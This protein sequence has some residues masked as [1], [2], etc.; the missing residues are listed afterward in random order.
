MKR[1]SLELTLKRGL[2][3]KVKITLGVLVM[4]LINGNVSYTD[5]IPKNISNVKVSESG[6]ISDISQL[7][8]NEVGGL[9]ISGSPVNKFE[10]DIQ[11]INVAVNIDPAKTSGVVNVLGMRSTASATEMADNLKINAEIIGDYTGGSSTVIGVQSLIYAGGEGEYLRLG[12][13]TKV[14]IK[15]DGDHK[16]LIATGLHVQGSDYTTITTIG[17]GSEININTSSGRISGIYTALAT[18]SNKKSKI[19]IEDDV[20][21]KVE[22]AKEETNTSAYDWVMA[23]N[24]Y[25][26]AE[27]I[28]GDRLTLEIKTEADALKGS[29]VANYTLNNKEEGNITIGN[30]AKITSELILKEK[31]G[32]VYTIVNQ[33]KSNLKIG[34]NAVISAKGENANEV[35]AISNMGDSNLTIGEG[36]NISVTGENSTSIVAIYNAKGNTTLNGGTYISSDNG[37]IYNT[38]GKVLIEDEGHTK[39]IQGYI[40]SAA[41]DAITKVM[42]DTNDSYLEGATYKTNEGVFDLGLKNKA[43]WYNTGESQVSTFNMEN[44]IVDMTQNHKGDTTTGSQYVFIDNATGAGGTYILDISP[45]DKEQKGD[46]TD[47]IYITKADTPQNNYIQAGKTS[48]T[49][50]VSHN[51]GDKINNSIL[52]ANTDKNIKFEGSEFSDISNVYDYK[53]V[54]E[55]NVKGETD[56]LDNW[57]VTGINKKEG[58]VVEKVEEDLTLNYMNAALSRLELDTIHKRLGEIRD[59]TSEDGVWA[60]IVSGEMEHDKSSGKFKN[61]YNM[62]QVGYDKRKE[63]EKGSVFTGFAVH[64]RDGKTDFRNGDGKNH[65]IGISMY[66]SFAY[67]DNSYTDIILKYNHLDNDYKSY[68]ENNQKLE[69][70]YNTWAGSLSLE[71]GKKYEKNAWYVTPHV[72][73]NYTYVKGADYS[74]NSGVRV[75]QRDIKSLIGRAGIY[76]GHDF[77]KSSHFVKAGVLHEFA[78]KYGAK[79]TGEDASLN[80]KYSGRDTW[81]EVGIGGQFKVG[82]TGTTHLYYDVEKTFGSDFETNWQASVGVR[83][84]L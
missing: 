84:E 66:K 35:M 61:D 39:K 1:K 64:K 46:K 65:N 31:S 56:S 2:K 16:D 76:A 37:A 62:L 63:T 83:I 75:E 19:V 21:I 12:K 20:K 4:F 36:S 74:M 52:I 79:I 68:T 67:N 22:V 23:I 72:Q 78:G 24:N 77:K 18:S 70:D 47:G 7:A 9:F 26:G 82:K 49:D 27:I 17:E 33:K 5:D 6:S 43:V 10:V 41:A 51:F 28:A 32:S 45:D 53:L 14:N 58:E 30:D 8:Y 38:G 60:R 57:Y 34:S 50:L 3:G 11:K 44:G 13:N 40:W 73:M 81:V 59:Y 69:A 42:L 15:T 80:K 54:L 29:K 25:E 55:Q 48:I 71:H